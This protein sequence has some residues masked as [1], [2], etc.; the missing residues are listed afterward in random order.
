MTIDRRTV[1]DTEWLLISLALELFIEAHEMTDQET[2]DRIA[3]D[4]FRV[5]GALKVYRDRKPAPPKMTS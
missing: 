5:V 4:G 3:R 2:V 1:D